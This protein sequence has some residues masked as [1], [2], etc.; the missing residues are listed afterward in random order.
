MGS[1][2][3]RYRRH[4][5]PIPKTMLAWQMTGAGFENVGEHGAPVRIEVPKPGPHEVLCR[6][7]A[8]GL[9]FSDVKLILAGNNHP[10]I[11]GRDLKKNPTRGGHE[12]SLTVAAV[13]EKE[14]DRYKV[15]ERYIIQSDIYH[16]GRGMAF[17]YVFPGGMSEYTIIPEEAL[18]GDEGSYLIP[19]EPDGL[20]YAEA[21]LI[22]PWACVEAAYRIRAR[23]SVREGGRALV[24]HL[25]G[26]KGAPEG[27]EKSAEVQVLERPSP[28]A[29]AELARSGA[30]AATEA[31][32]TDP[33]EQAGFDD[34]AV[35]GAGKDSKPILEA[36]LSALRRGGFLCLLDFGEL[37]HDVTVDIGRVHYQDIRIVAGRTVA[38][39]YT[40]NTREDLLPGG[41]V[42]MS[43]AAGPMGQMH[44][45][46]AVEH[47]R[48][49]RLVVVSDLS[50]ARLEYTVKRVEGLARSKGIELIAMNP[51]RF[52]DASAFESELLFLTKGTGFDDVVLCAPVGALVSSAVRQSA[53][54]AVV[55]IFA[56][57]ALG[58]TAQLDLDAIAR[59]HVRIVGSSG[60]RLAD[61]QYVASRAESGKLATGVSVGAIGGCLQMLEGLIALKEGRF[62]GKTVIYPAV[63]DFPLI[64]V[65][66]IPS[67]FP[68]LAMHLGPG[69][70]WTKSAEETFLEETLQ[71]PD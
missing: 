54:L 32:F 6:V 58:T 20:S 56:G 57:V 35:I 11:K 62:P 34:I 12:L 2:L 21:A 15:G 3:E 63:K 19:L 60:S 42:H 28:E 46:R 5:Y 44:V 66:D 48:P 33:S 67:K 26:G 45:Q 47:D 24:I 59:K 65:G 36:A 29:I 41:A 18:H 68:K 53:N 50:D 22:E 4:D 70:V 10:R 51:K 7:D 30:K 39:A 61:M 13:G 55:N 69:C 14:N 43:G 71:L 49:P 1:K 64:A 31:L 27:F 25:G 52:P 23:T 8:V 40:S 17:G 37:P 16:K 9:C 38:E